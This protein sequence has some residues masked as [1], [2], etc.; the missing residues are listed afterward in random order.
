MANYIGAIGGGVT[1]ELKQL[2]AQR[3]FEEKQ[4]AM[5][6]DMAQQRALQSRGL[7]QGDVRLGLEGR[8]LGQESEQFGQRMGLDRDKLTQEGK[9]FDVTSGQ[10]QQGID[11]D[12]E[13]QPTR[14]RLTAAQ[15]GDI[16]RKPTAEA[17]NRSFITG[18]DRAQH[19]YQMGE[20]G[21]QGANAVR[22]AGVRA[23]AA[24]DARTTK[25]PTGAER[26]TLAFFNRALEG[27]KTA[28]ELED[29]I[30]NAGLASQAQQ[31]YAPNMLQT[32]GQQR[33]R[34]AQRSFTE[35]RLRKES[36]AAINPSEYENDSKTYFAQPGDSPA[37]RKQK[38]DARRTLL[39][40]LGN[41]AGNALREYY[42]DATNLDTIVGGTGTG[43]HTGGGGGDAAAKAAELLKKYGGG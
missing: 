23:D 22:V 31:Q 16:E 14:I 29:A 39:K 41:A 7:A 18:R 25:P 15:A 10:R 40:G 38:R 27:D 13:F 21:A 37:V 26:Q 35:A 30:A 19:G 34:Q 42:G 4:K 11:L 3:L 6:E 28:A 8:R 33:Y 9:Q 36:G 24:A 5:L 2:V 1:D 43:D 12:K 20:I 17:E 32:E